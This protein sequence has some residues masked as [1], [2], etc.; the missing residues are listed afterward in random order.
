MTPY[1]EAEDRICKAKEEL[2]LGRLYL[3]EVPASLADL[4]SL[5]RLN[6]AGN[7]LTDVPKWLGNLTELRVLKLSELNLTTVPD[8][9]ATS[10]S[11]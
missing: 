5:Q 6:L 11:S 2:D 7:K 9:W 3:T 4:R 8:G 1:E 10:P